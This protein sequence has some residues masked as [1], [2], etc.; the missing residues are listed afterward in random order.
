MS[1]P[2]PTSDDDFSA[3]PPSPDL[4]A[5]EYALG[6][7]DAEQ[8]RRSQGRIDADPAFAARVAA[9]ERRLAGL[10]AGITPAPPPPH[11]WPGIRR[12]LGW[13]A[14]EGARGG[15]WQSVAFW[16]AAAAAAVVVASALA[17]L[18]TTRGVQPPVTTAPLAQAVTTLRFDDGTPAYLATLDTTSGAILLV[19]V[20]SAPDAEGRVPELWLIPA[21]EGPRSLGVVTPDRARTIAVPVELRRAMTAGSVLAISLEPVGGAPQGVPTGP[22]VAKGSIASI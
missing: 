18:Y 12:R 2:G 19:P 13:P 22:I 6:V 8:R 7:Q 20:P 10:F 14:V 5:A 15:L 11:V 21:G 1:T 9:W 3:D 17:V 4:E 16:R